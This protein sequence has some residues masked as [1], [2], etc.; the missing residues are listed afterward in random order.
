MRH[1]GGTLW[2]VRSSLGC[3]FGFD[4]LCDSF[5]SCTHAVLGK[6]N[7]GRTDTQHRGDLPRR[8]VLKNAVIKDLV[9]LWIGVLAHS[10]QGHLENVVTPFLV[11]ILVDL[12]IG[13]WHWRRRLLRS[14]VPVFGILLRQLPCAV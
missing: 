12:R 7:P 13:R 3:E 2:S 10:C 1:E 5:Y 9:M 14:R 6:V 8:H 11:P 4:F